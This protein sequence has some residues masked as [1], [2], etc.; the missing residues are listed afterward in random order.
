LLKDLLYFDSLIY[1]P[2]H[3]ESIEEYCTTLHLGKELFTNKIKEIELYEKHGLIR[4]Y[5]HQERTSG[6]QN[7]MDFSKRY[8]PEEISDD[9]SLIIKDDQ[10][11][12]A[13]EQFESFKFSI[14][15]NM[16][17]VEDI[18]YTAFSGMTESM[19]LGS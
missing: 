3:F 19:E 9:F 15:S 11:L 1:S 13:W 16:N 5:S 10:F 18:L 8:T 7:L 17:S 2:S 6:L 4:E 14:P 12:K